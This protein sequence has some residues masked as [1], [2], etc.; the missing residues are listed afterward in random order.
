MFRAT[1]FLKHPQ[2]QQDIEAQF[3]QD[4]NSQKSEDSEEGGTS[5][6]EEQESEKSWLEDEGIKFE[7]GINLKLGLV[8]TIMFVLNCLWAP[9]LPKMQEMAVANFAR[10]VEACASLR[11]PS[12]VLA[13]KAFATM[14]CE[15]E[16]SPDDFAFDVEACTSGPTP[17]T[18]QSAKAMASILCEADGDDSKDDSQLPWLANV[19]HNLLVTFGTIL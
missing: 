18:V 7:D 15:E 8:L 17:A 2:T 4:D 5:E 3:L 13:A 10:D 12:T 6:D 19:F 9:V 16:A 14:V 11:T 1:R